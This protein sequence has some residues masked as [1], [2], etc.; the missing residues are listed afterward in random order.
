MYYILYI[1]TGQIILNPYN[2]DSRSFDTKD[3]AIKWLDETINYF[4]NSNYFGPQEKRF[5]EEYEIIER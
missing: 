5:P 2:N 4:S 3:K 1:P